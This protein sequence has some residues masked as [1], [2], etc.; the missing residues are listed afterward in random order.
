MKKQTAKRGGKREGAGRP[1]EGKKNYTVSL[2]EKHVDRAKKREDNFSA[3]L[4]RLLT[5][6]LG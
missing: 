4:D 6:F 2:T 5:E 1:P 3:L